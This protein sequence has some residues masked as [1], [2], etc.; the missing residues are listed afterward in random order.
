MCVCSETEAVANL[1]SNSLCSSRLVVLFSRLPSAAFQGCVAML[2][3]LEFC[4]CFVAVYKMGSGDDLKGGSQ[5][6]ICG[7]NITQ[8]PVIQF[9]KL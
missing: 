3:Y 1:F 7:R 8:K 4:S 6:K 2:I 5:M 9:Y